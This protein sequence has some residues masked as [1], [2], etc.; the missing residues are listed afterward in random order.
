M[1]DRS[2]W[3][4]K[5]DGIFRKSKKQSS[6]GISRKMTK[7]K[8]TTGMVKIT[9]LG[10]EKDKEIRESN[11]K[12]VSENKFLR[13]ELEKLMTRFDA[14]EKAQAENG[15]KMRVN[16]KIATSN[17][18]ETLVEDEGDMEVS[19]EAQTRNWTQ[20]RFVGEEPSQQEW[21]KKRPVAQVPYSKKQEQIQMEQAKA[22]QGT[23]GTSAQ[24]NRA[25][26]TTTSGNDNMSEN[27]EECHVG[28]APAGPKFSGRVKVDRLKAD[29]VVNK[30]AE[31]NVKVYLKQIN[32]E[33]TMISCCPKDRE[34][35]CNTLI[36]TGHRGHS[37]QTKEDREEKR[38]L[39]GVNGSF[40][41]VVVRE[42]IME[43]L[44]G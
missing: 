12:L 24:S 15:G 25:N 42:A 43:K 28:K 40:G 26:K 32:K 18:Y 20:N 34:N 33:Q 44:N 22:K 3:S 4:K 23:S 35:V 39:K 16:S 29:V 7:G 2:E 6:R 8:A 30:L 27:G 10:K 31:Q 38:L 5:V 36:E 41:P 19:N 1:C 13:D 11:K 17:R 37:F 21:K 14:M 9:S